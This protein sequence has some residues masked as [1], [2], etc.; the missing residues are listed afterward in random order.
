[1][2]IILIDRVVEL[3]R[4]RQAWESAFAADR[5]ASIFMSWPWLTTWMQVGPYPRWAVLAAREDSRSPCVGFFPVNVRGRP[6]ALRM[7]QVREIH[8]A[9]DP[10]ADFTGF[11]CHPQTER[12]AIEAIAE[13]IAS[14]MR[15]ER[16]R[17]KEVSDPRM[18]FFLNRLAQH[19]NDIQD[20]QGTCCPYVPLPPTWDEFMQQHPSHELRKKLRIVERDFQVRHLDAENQRTQIDAIVSMSEAYDYHTQGGNLPRFRRLFEAAAEAGFARILAIWDGP[21]PVAAIGGFLDEKA[22]SLCIYCTAFDDRY[23]H[24]SPGRVVNALAL[25]Y[26]IEQKLKSV[27]FLRGDEAYKFQFGAQRRFTR[28]ITVTRRGL[29]VATRMTLNR[30]RQLLRI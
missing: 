10:G 23:K 27:D 6:G 3:T 8:M 7:D 5:H 2:E 22:S 12:T 17:L 9:G 21:W 25:R 11:V 16:M 4:H 29:G 18:E 13:Y 15:W 26:A 20:C 28:N 30:T 19:E 1:M 24:V 14:H